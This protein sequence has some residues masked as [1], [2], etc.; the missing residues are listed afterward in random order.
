MLKLVG[1]FA[2]AFA[3]MSAAGT[4]LNSIVFNTAPVPTLDDIGMIV[5]TLVV[6]VAGGIAARRRGDRKTK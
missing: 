5:L 2:L 4:S 6:A 3:A 1:F